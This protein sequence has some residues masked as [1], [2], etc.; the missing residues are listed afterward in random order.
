MSQ[1]SAG[2][3]AYGC[4]QVVM[5]IFGPEGCDRDGHDI[6]SIIVG[7]FG[8]FDNVSPLAPRAP[9]QEF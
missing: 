1:P 6:R 5:E 9:L 3:A 2:A 8:F 4:W 7:T